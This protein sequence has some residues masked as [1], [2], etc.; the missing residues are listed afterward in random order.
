[1]QIV[2]VISSCYDFSMKI[3]YPTSWQDYELLDTGGG[4]KLE[5]FGKYILSRPEPDAIWQK[6]LPDTAWEKADAKFVKSDLSLE[7]GKWITK[8]DFPQKW[9]I[10]YGNLFFYLRLTPFKHTGIFPEQSVH[11]D[12]LTE[13]IGKA[14]C[15]PKILN[16]FGYTG[17]ASLT[18]AKA[19]AQV[20]H[21]DASKPS[22]GWA[23]EN[24]TLSGLSHLPIR[25]I[26]DD[27]L[28]FVSREIKR[29]QFYDGLIMDPPAFGH[30]PNK[31][32]WKFSSSFPKLLTLCKNIL[33]TNPLFIIVNAYA[34]SSSFLMLHNTLGQFVQN[35]PGTVESGELALK[36]TSAGKLLSTGI[37]SR[38][39]SEQK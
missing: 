22:I 14:L 1:M 16:L 19:G 38:W 25:W 23:R 24:Q 3:L 36:E 5:R 34:V 6:T 9:T 27:V 7:N 26:N 32:I 8:K 13:K 21:I 11:W 12:W 33:S 28:K 31:Q 30:G 29:K 18:A 39:S 10:S 15:P 20:T 2:I 35:L 37:F 4:Q 17:A